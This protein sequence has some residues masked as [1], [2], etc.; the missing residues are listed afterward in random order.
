MNLSLKLPQRAIT[1]FLY[2]PPRWGG[3][4][5]PCVVDELHIHVVSSAFKLLDT[6]NDPRVRDI[7]HHELLKTANIRR[8]DLQSAQDFLNSLPPPSPW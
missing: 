7:A 5:I 2:T 6:R 8:R 4:G 3:L 1:S